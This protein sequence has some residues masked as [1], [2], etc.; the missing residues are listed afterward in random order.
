MTDPRVQGDYEYDGDNLH[1]T[2]DTGTDFDISG[3]SAEGC[4]EKLGID[5]ESGTFD[6]PEGDWDDLAH[7]SFR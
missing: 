2:T 4:A 7:G 5:G 1:I 6:V 3:D